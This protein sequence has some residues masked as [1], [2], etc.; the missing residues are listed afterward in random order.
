MD[1]KKIIIFGNIF[2]SVCAVVMSLYTYYTFGTEPDAIYLLF[3]FFATLTSY[4][5]HWYL[6][7]DVSGPSPRFDW[8]D[9]NK[10]ILF[11]LFLISISATSMLIYQLRD[12]FFILAVTA[13]LTFIYSAAKIAEKP[14]VYLRKIIIG[15]TAYLALIWTFVTAVLPL[16]ISRHD[17]NYSEI[18]F[19]LNRF[20]LIYTI[21][22]LFDYRDREEDRRNKVKNFVGQLSR[23]TLKNFYFFF[24]GLF[25]L[26]AVLMY[27]NG[28]G[29][30]DMIIILIPGILLLFTF[31]YSVNTIS[32]YWY[33]FFL[34]GLMMMS[35]VLYLLKMLIL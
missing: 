5:F 8:V 34:D 15:K 23:K 10:K 17:I 24:L 32:D 3:I 1:F 14:F 22:I 9:K 11:L 21:C 33:Y 2:I 16:V 25:F 28:T 19:I 6:T 29:T 30:L 27:F 12:H 18:L 20:L 13:I 26:S 7:P 31:E 35:G 4:S